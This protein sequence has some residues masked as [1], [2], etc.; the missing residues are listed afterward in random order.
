M[1]ANHIP[2]W[3]KQFSEGRETGSRLCCRV[4]RGALDLR[5]QLRQFRGYWCA[6]RPGVLR[7]VRHC[8]LRMR[9]RSYQ[10]H[11][12][13]PDSR[14]FIVNGIIESPIVRLSA[15]ERPSGYAVLRA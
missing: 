14:L 1:I 6:D 15:G 12:Y 3:E 8:L 2:D 11:E 7:T 9:K 13:R 10:A 4:R 5:F